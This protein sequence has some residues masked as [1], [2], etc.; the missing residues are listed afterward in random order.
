MPLQPFAYCEV[1]HV[2]RIMPDSTEES[3]ERYE[4]DR[5]AQLESDYPGADVY[6]H[7][8]H[9]M[10]GLVHDTITRMYGPIDTTG[11]RRL[12]GTITT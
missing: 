6:I 1:V 9:D 10:G 8:S 3:N 5:R 11:N 2:Y 7:H 4:L 12:W